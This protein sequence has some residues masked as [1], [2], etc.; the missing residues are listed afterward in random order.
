MICT[1]HLQMPLLLS[2][3]YTIW[4][5]FFAYCLAL[6]HNLFL[7]P[8]ILLVPYNCAT[9]IV[10]YMIMFAYYSEQWRSSYLCV[11]VCLCWVWVSYIMLEVRAVW[12]IY[13]TNGEI[14]T[15]RE[16]KKKER[17]RDRKTAFLLYSSGQRFSL[18]QF[19]L[20]S[21][22]WNGDNC[23]WYANQLFCISS[24]AHSLYLCSSVHT[25]K[26]QNSSI[27]NASY[28]FC[29]CV[30]ALWAVSPFFR[31]KCDSLSYPSFDLI[32]LWQNHVRP[33]ILMLSPLID[34]SH[35]LKYFV[36]WLKR[37]WFVEYV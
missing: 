36:C 15:E 34:I 19:S 4:L 17:E 13:H 24:L 33:I 8:F 11:C 21:G 9:F 23:L 32:L 29:M 16:R 20:D 18:L 12:R 37:Q 28:S 5:A 3:I 7:L 30:S 10:D 2:F 26:T 31:I 25:P 6:L 22:W 27:I 14:D 35:N 1:T